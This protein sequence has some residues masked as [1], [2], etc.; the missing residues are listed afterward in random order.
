MTTGS[1]AAFYFVDGLISYAESPTAPGLGVRLVAAGRLSWQEWAELRTS[2]LTHSDLPTVLRA[3]GVLD[4]NEFN[5]VVRS[6]VVDALFELVVADD[7]ALG[8]R[9]VPSPVGWAGWTGSSVRLD[10]DTVVDE[11]AAAAVSALQRRVTT[12]DVL[13]PQ[14]PAGAVVLSHTEWL[15]RW[16]LDGDQTVRQLAWRTGLSLVDAIRAAAGLLAADLCRPASPRP[17]EP[18]QG[19][20]PPRPTPVETSSLLATHGE[21]AATDRVEAA[22]AAGTPGP[23]A[24][25]AGSEDDEHL[26]AGA[27]GLLPRRTAQARPWDAAQPN[28]PPV[29]LT[30]V[31]VLTHILQK[32]KAGE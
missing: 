31:T 18:A 3:A 4:E 21:P 17:S 13:V 32:L 26:P 9:A 8:A 30:D 19:Q 15:L 22:A 2:A 24:Q 28:V 1:Q 5:S 14:D 23:L 27:P 12:D 29:A 25:H 20:L 7:P 10:I 6:G 11:A 16:G